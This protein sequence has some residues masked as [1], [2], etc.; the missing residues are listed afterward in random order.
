VLGVGDAPVVAREEVQVQVQARRRRRARLRG[1]LAPQLRRRR[2]LLRVRLLLRLPSAVDP[3]A[4][5]QGAAAREAEEGRGFGRRGRGIRS[6]GRS[7]SRRRSPSRPPSRPRAG[8]AR[9]RRRP[10]PARAPRNPSMRTRISGFT[11]NR[12]TVMVFYDSAAI[13]VS[14]IATFPSVAAYC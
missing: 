4:G 10:C 1:L 11:G 5:G 13:V 9:P 8:A 3:A 12:A 6:R 7:L 2:R 14:V